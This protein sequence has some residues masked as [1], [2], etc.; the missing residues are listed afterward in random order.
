[1]SPQRYGVLVAAAL[2]QSCQPTG[3]PSADIANPKPAASS[4]QSANSISGLTIK[5]GE[6]AE[7][8]VEFDYTVERG[9]PAM[10]RLEFAPRADTAPAGFRPFVPVGVPNPS[11]HH[12]RK[13]VQY[14]GQGTTEE[15][16]VSLVDVNDSKVLVSQRIEIAITWPTQ[17]ERDFSTA[18]AMIENGS[19][20]QLRQARETLERL[21][22]KNPQFDAAYVELA[23]I[24]MKTNWG[25][26]GFHQAETLLDSALKIRPESANAK[27][28]LGYV[29]T[30]QHRFDE[31]QPL[32]VD[33]AR[34]D[35]PNLWLWTNW[36]EMFDMQG[37][38]D[39][40][41]VKYRETIAR[42]LRS[43]KYQR[44]RENAYVTP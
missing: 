22:G 39:Q 11:Q 7:L 17:D 20:D 5:P 41:I 12:I 40:A 25:P 31:A 44:A 15:A 14:P 30:H 16:I 8:L 3:A 29:Y 32:F 43:T 34:T 42:P 4:A 36:G 33:A 23:R 26:A 28:L 2:V 24:A 38:T 6:D 19:D 10:F 37:Q 21:V 27:I 13:H 18:F 35:P 1:V 9:L